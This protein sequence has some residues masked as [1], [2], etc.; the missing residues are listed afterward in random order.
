MAFALLTTSALSSLVDPVRY[1]LSTDPCL[2]IVADHHAFAMPTCLDT[3]T[4]TTALT[5]TPYTH[6]V[7]D[8]KASTRSTPS[9]NY[10]T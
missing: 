4:L 10:S 2:C 7:S 3:R 5:L 9:M 6:N 8:D 1:G